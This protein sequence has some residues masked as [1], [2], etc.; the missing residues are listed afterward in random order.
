MK[1]HRYF[2]Y[3]MASRSHNFY[4]G[5]TSSLRRR[6]LQHKNHTFQ[7]FTARYNIDRLVYYAVYSDICNAI[8]REKQLK[9]WSREKKIALIEGMNPTWQDLSEGWYDEFVMVV[10][11]TAD[12]STSRSPD[13]Q[14][15]RVED[16]AGERSAQDDKS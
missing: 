2:V 11:S 10:K 13:P 9:R 16:K 4:V 3:V 12:P 14:T 5:V 8:V 15:T 7:G 6:V 1:E